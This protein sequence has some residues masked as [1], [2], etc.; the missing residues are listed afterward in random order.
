LKAAGKPK[1][2]KGENTGMPLVVAQEPVIY[3]NFITGAG[4]RAIGVGYPSNAS[5]AWSAEALNLAI[6]WRGAFIDAARHWNGRGGGQQPPLGY[7][8]FRPA[9]LSQPFAVLAEGATWPALEKGGRAA[10]Y[11]WRGY[12]LDAKRVPTFHYEWEGVKVSEHYEVAGDALTGEGKLV[13][14][15]KLDGKIPAGALFRVASAAKI[16]PQGA[17]FLVEDGRAVQEIA[18]DSKFIVTA[19]GAKLSGKDLTLPARAEIKVTYSW[20]KL[21]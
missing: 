4:N 11:T 20:P 8:V 9:A 6:A 19:E 17:G 14:T 12:D 18:T 1:K 21:H 15:L 3:R 2:N 10:G 7:D 13:R 5:I 16:T